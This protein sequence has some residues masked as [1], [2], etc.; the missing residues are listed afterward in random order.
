MPKTFITL[1]LTQK[2]QCMSWQK[3]HHLRSNQ[4][5]LAIGRCF[6]VFH[7]FALHIADRRWW[8]TNR[9]PR[10]PS[11]KGDSGNP[12]DHEGLRPASATRAVTIVVAAAAAPETLTAS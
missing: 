9:A 4:R 10:A 1:W 7:D 5:I 12:A 6:D 8:P 3:G 11:E 2:E